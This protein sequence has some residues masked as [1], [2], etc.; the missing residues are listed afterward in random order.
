MS[1]L[2]MIQQIFARFKAGSFQVLPQIGRGHSSIMDAPNGLW[3]RYIAPFWSEGGSNMTDVK[4][5][6]RILAILTAVN[7][8]GGMARYL[9][10]SEY[11]TWYTFDGRLLYILAEWR[12]SK[13]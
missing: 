6:G 3:Y 8:S 5:Q 1:E 2:L 11:L 9:R 10:S 13:K 7:I 4:N 12:S